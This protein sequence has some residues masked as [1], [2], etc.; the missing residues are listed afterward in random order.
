MKRPH[1]IPPIDTDAELTRLR[2]LL[3]CYIKHSPA[4]E[5]GAAA[6]PSRESSNPVTASAGAA[7]PASGDLSLESRR[8]G[9]RGE[10]G[11]AVSGRLCC[12]D[13]AVLPPADP[14]HETPRGST[15]IHD[16][17]CW[18]GVH[19]DALSPY[20]GIVWVACACMS[21]AAWVL[22]LTALGVL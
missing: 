1:R 16:G 2:A 9:D 22:A 12:G 3:D 15:F 7:S 13:R 10:P 14:A 8:H 20:R 18:D 21:I 6:A 4:R 5:D 17:T 11:T 19:D